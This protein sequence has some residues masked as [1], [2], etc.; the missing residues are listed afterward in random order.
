MAHDEAT[1]L[2]RFTSI[3]II[4]ISKLI[5]KL[6]ERLTESTSRYAIVALTAPLLVLFCFGVQLL[7]KPW[8][9]TFDCLDDKFTIDSRM[10]GPRNNDAE[11]AIAIE[12]DQLRESKPPKSIVRKYQRISEELRIRI[13]YGG[14]V[15]LR[16]LSV[17]TQKCELWE[18]R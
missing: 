13:E 16:L 8:P 9:K 12:M 5:Y 14:T 15:G 1:L 7:A 11:V 2:K 4:D 3:D 6:P 18:K 10:V 17:S